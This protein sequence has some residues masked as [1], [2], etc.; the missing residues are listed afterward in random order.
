[1]KDDSLSPVRGRSMVL[2]QI[3]VVVVLGGSFLLWNF[4]LTSSTGPKPSGG[5]IKERGAGL[6]S[7]S[8]AAPFLARTSPALDERLHEKALEFVVRATR[9]SIGVLFRC[10]LL[11]FA[12]AQ[13]GMSSFRNTD[14]A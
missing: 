4:D 3:G 14:V 1:M 13:S 12:F 8:S 2:L 10:G 7:N 6:R 11:A 5:N 9:L